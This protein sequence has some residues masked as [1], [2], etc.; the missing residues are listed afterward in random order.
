LYSLDCIWKAGQYLDN[1]IR[2]QCNSLEI[3]CGPTKCFELLE[4]HSTGGPDIA[5][6]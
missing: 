2:V 6:I 4:G 3:N 1:Y 5:G